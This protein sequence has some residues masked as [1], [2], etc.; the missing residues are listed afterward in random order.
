MEIIKRS[1]R[2]VLGSDS[3]P[4]GLA[5]QAFSFGL[6]T[7][8]EG[9]S[10]T[11]RLWRLSQAKPGEPEVLKF[12]NL[13]H[14]ISIRPGTPDAKTAINNFIRE[15]YGFVRPAQPVTMVDAGAY[16][17][18]TSAYFLSRY[19]QLKI[20]ALEPD[21]ANF[22]MARKNLNAY[23]NRVLLYNKALSSRAG[24]VFISGEYDGACISKNGVQIEATTLP[25]IMSAM[26]W[27]VLS[28]LKMDIEGEE[29]NVLDES[30]EAWLKRVGLIIVETHGSAIESKIR[31]ILERSSFSVKQYRS[32][33][34]CH[35]KGQA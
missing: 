16:I 10:M 11:R 27:D 35:N 3:V 13:R 28:V 12:K 30:A 1:V 9:P 15:D 5:S 14:A 8:R 32:C 25:A 6:V 7:L 33:W 2:A 22:E 4:Y 19:P 34:F 31:P 20:A 21:P 29:A 18:D 24:S 17:G 23:G 26:G